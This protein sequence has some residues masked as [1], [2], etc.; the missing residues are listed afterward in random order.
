[1]DERGRELDD[2][3]FVSVTFFLASFDL[4]AEVPITHR[5]Y[6]MRNYAIYI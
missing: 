6:V 2:K 4:S 1:M 5:F 3:Q